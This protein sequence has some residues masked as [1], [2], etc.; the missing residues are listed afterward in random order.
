MSV[1]EKHRDLSEARI[2][3]FDR[4][5]VVVEDFEASGFILDVGGGGEGIIGRLKGNQVVAIDSRREELEEAAEGP[6]KIV[7]D[8]RELHFLDGS[9]DVVTS[10]FTLMY[11]EE[12]DHRTVFGEVR[13]VLRP[14][15]RFLIWDVEMPPRVQDEQ[16]IAVFPLV[17]ELPT[18]EVETGY[19]S[20]WPREPLTVSGYVDLAEAVGFDVL[21]QR[22]SR[23]IFYLE[24]HRE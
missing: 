4:Q 12:E 10:F 1:S 3:R 11:L 16:D 14:G 6:L 19:G 9:F 17:I 13:R 2:H 22:Q 20:Y 15:G 5:R 24:L 7:M 21:G 8:A 18:A 23:D